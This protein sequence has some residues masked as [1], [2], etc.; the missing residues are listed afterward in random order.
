MGYSP[1][2]EAVVAAS[3]AVLF[4]PAA[5]LMPPDHVQ[6]GSSSTDARSPQVDL[7][8]ASPDAG[9]PLRV[10]FL[11][12]SYTYVNDLPSV[13]RALGAATPGAA[14]VVDSVTLGGARLM[15]L[16][17][18]T[19]ARRRIARG[20][21]NVVVLQGQSLEAAGTAEYFYKYGRLFAGAVAAAGAR[22]AW[23]ATWARQVGYTSDYTTPTFMTR[24]I[25][26]AYRTAADE[27]GGILARVGSAWQLALA[28]LPAVALYADDG[29]HPTKAATLLTACVMLEAI[30]GRAPVVPDP[31]PF[32]IDRTAA[33]ALC[34][35]AK[36]V[37]K[38]C[39]CRRAERVETTYGALSALRGDCDAAGE[40]THLACNSA[41]DTF[42]ASRECP[43]LASGFGPTTS[44]GDDVDVTCVTG[45][46]MSTTFAELKSFVSAC[47]RSAALA[48]SDCGI[49][50]NRL[51]ASKGALGG[52]G[53]TGVA[54][55]Q[56]SVTCVPSRD[57]MALTVSY[58]MLVNYKSG[59]DGVA[60]HGG[61]DCNAAIESFCREQGFAGGFGP[62]EIYP[63]QTSAT[64]SKDNAQ[65]P[66]PEKDKAQIVCLSW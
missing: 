45:S 21:W 4:L 52:F 32:G 31:T 10:L 17:E 30:T 50:I 59:C 55:D 15:E 6:D 22:T 51:C 5:C 7:K 62:S 48:G 61:P 64:G 39:G 43:A 11:G 56:V 38:P 14:V 46:R 49:A 33:K 13:V 3:L 18:T 12:N 47:D 28:E 44:S 53:P 23:Y 25:E 54:G 41:I 36:R 40:P 58:G 27:S 8:P 2:R 66:V 1:H 9:V 29:S 16:W 19:D 65:I 37:A 20:G 63:V 34:A 35:L 26:N 24:A 57:A 60:A 42:C